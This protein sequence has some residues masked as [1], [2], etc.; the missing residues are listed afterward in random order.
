MDGIG[1]SLL[2][3]PVQVDK[4][5]KV[6][7]FHADTYIFDLEDSV[8]DDNKWQA[9]NILEIFL[10]KFQTR[11]G[12]FVRINP[13]YAKREWN[14]LRDLENIDGIVIPKV[15]E[16]QQIEVLDN[17]HKKYLMA[18]IE[19]PKGMIN[20]DKI[21]NNPK[22]TAIGF[23]AEDYCV[24]TGMK[25]KSSLL[26]PLKVRLIMYAKAYGKKV[27]DMVDTNFSNIETYR[28]EVEVSRDLGFDGKFVIHPKQ[29]EI[30]NEIYH[31]KNIN[32]M[33]EIIKAYEANNNGFMLYD[34][35]AYEK[36]H[37]ENLKRQLE[38]YR[39][40]SGGKIE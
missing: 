34:G 5:E 40:K 21:M 18:L 16:P 19:T 35:I 7:R 31:D 29:V 15:E 6:D 11:A 39:E 33:K 14:V 30:V 2:F 23:G 3:V 38:N 25:K 22:I 10:R 36:P 26:L 4:L 37:I 1:S 9:L 17:Y 8:K 32:Y 28:E 13:E 24:C 27:Y 12:V 20:L